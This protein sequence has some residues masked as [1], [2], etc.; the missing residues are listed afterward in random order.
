MIKMEGSFLFRLY[1]IFF[2]LLHFGFICE[3]MLLA[4]IFKGHILI[5]A[6]ERTANSS[7]NF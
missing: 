4:P 1:R 7:G 6:L 3:D 5:L 2:P